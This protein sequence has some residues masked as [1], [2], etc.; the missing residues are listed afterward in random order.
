MLVC[1]IRWISAAHVDSYSRTRKQE[2]SQRLAPNVLN[3]ETSDVHLFI[4]AAGIECDECK[5]S[6]SRSHFLHS[7]NL[8]PLFFPR[9]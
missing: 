8:F 6:V 4:V 2:N 3:H 7:I 5:G 1:I 9:T